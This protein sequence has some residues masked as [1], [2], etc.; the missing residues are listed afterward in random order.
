MILALVIGVAW[1]AIVAF[2]FVLCVEAS[3]T[4]R[5]SRRR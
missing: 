4:D 3:H 1:A 2:M 5:D